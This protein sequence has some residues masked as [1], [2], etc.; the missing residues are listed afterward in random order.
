MKRLLL[1]LFILATLLLPVAAAK[2]KPPRYDLQPNAVYEVSVRRVVD[3][4]T[5]V[6]DFSM[7]EQE[8]V[9]LIGVNTPE[10]VHPKKPGAGAKER[11][12]EG[13][14]INNKKRSREAPL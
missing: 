4:D 13:L 10:T 9:R 1:S 7:G 12:M 11:T 6:V 2:P 14:G 5:I 3:G 8:R